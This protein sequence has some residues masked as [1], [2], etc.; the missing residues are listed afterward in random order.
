MTA[1]LRHLHAA[2]LAAADESRAT[3]RQLSTQQQVVF[4]TLEI[5]Y[6]TKYFSLPGCTGEIVTCTIC[7][8][9]GNKII[10]IALTEIMMSCEKIKTM[11]NSFLLPHFRDLCSLIKW[12]KKILSGI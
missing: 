9:Q 10:R 3:A 6:K 7:R 12:L 2:Q 1:A 8:Q 5:F 11:R 4:L